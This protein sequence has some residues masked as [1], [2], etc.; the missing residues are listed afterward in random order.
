MF[1]DDIDKSNQ[2]F[3]FQELEERFPPIQVKLQ[4][5]RF[6]T[7]VKCIK[8]KLTSLTGQV[9]YIVEFQGGQVRQV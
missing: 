5:W 7:S 3:F 2:I 4:P 9:I 1:I 8:G 6:P